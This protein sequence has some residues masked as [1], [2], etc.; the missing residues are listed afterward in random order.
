MTP[1]V[2]TSSAQA[3]ASAQ[4]ID[5]TSK[6]SAVP[7]IT[8]G[9]GVQGSSASS[10]AQAFSVDISNNQSNNQSFISVT[11]SLHSTV[12]TKIKEKKTNEFV[13]FSIIFDEDCRINSKFTLDFLTPGL[14]SHS[15]FFLTIDQWADVFAK[16]A[17]VVRL[18]YPDSTNR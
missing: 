7:S 15:I 9:D 1:G 3:I 6:A 2:V 18:K 8:T 4:R 13:E 12:H 16:F 17:S 14:R 10:P 11:L 5:T